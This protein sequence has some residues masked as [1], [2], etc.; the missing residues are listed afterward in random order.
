MPK[1]INPYVLL[2][3]S[4]CAHPHFIDQGT[5]VKRGSHLL[6]SGRTEI[7]TEVCNSKVCTPH[8]YGLPCCLQRDLPFCA[9]SPWIG[10][11]SLGLGWVLAVGF[12]VGTL[13]V[14]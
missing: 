7:Q 11:I 1:F 6:K 13:P 10:P 5:G 4:A 14:I 3:G 8:F 2:G 9:T 12:S